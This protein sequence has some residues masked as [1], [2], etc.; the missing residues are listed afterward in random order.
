MNGPEFI[1][2]KEA[3]ER[4]GLTPAWF[5]RKRVDHSGPP[6]IKDH[7]SKKIRYRLTMIDAWFEKLGVFPKT[8]P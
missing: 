4:Y 8:P 7:K 6:F 2:E 1:D 5:Q 3:S